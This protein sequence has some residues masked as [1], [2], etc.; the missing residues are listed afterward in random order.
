MICILLSEPDRTDEAV[1]CYL[2]E[3]TSVR[4]NTPKKISLLFVRA[5]QR[6]CPLG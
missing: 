5:D 6:V 1:F 4:P 3:N 2:R